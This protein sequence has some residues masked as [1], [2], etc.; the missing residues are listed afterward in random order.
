MKRLVRPLLSA[1]LALGLAISVAPVASAK[2]G[3]G[4]GHGDS[5]E[6]RGEH[7]RRHHSGGGESRSYGRS[8]RDG[9][10]EKR[11]WRSEGSGSRSRGSREWGGSSSR[12]SAREWRGSDSRSPRWR[13]SITRRLESRSG[14]RR[15][16]D[17]RGSRS[18]GEVR[19][20]D[21]YDG[22]RYDRR[23]RS[24]DWNRGGYRTSFRT[25]THYRDVYYSC[26]H[27]YSA[28]AARPYYVASFHRPRYVYH[29]GFSVG[30]VIGLT[31][32]YGYSYFD[33]YCDVG[34]SNLG[35]YYDHCYDHGHP[36]VILVLD[37]YSGSPI[38]S[39]IYQSG[40]WVVD[41]CY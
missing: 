23:W 40:S 38:G 15:S 27:G 11:A 13:S 9:G 32:G 14:D 41:D 25:R 21:S 19:Y 6:S 26:D 33:P 36:E 18:T 29:S 2:G 8:H 35:Y 31:A 16:R 5:S 30:F 17:W 39:C 1:L 37:V 12:S 22:D 20:R 3:H 7:S 28:C 10:S 24:G 34:F 4:K